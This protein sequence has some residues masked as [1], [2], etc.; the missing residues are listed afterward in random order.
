M[1][2]EKNFINKLNNFNADNPIK[3]FKD[4]WV[5]EKTYQKHLEKR[6]KEGIIRNEK[7]YLLKTFKTLSEYDLMLIFE[8]LNDNG[9]NRIHYNKKDEWAVIIG[10]NGDILTSYEKKEKI[11][12]IIKKNEERNL[13]LRVNKSRKEENEI[14]KK[15]TS[16][17]NRLG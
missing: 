5:S 10:E 11:Q 2:I 15:A 3:S 6:F 4:L 16:I 17:L 14:T 7:D 8:N 13:K 1:E 12:E 9:W